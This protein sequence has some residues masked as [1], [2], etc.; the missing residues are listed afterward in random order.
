MS[1]RPRSADVI[2]AVAGIPLSA[3]IVLL[4]VALVL[5]IIVGLLY[6]IPAY[7]RYKRKQRYKR[8]KD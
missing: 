6:G 2:S 4:G 5:A 8:R 3:P 1:H 7:Q